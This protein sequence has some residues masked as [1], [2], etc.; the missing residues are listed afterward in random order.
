MD[1]ELRL[2]VRA[3]PLALAPLAMLAVRRLVAVASRPWCDATASAI[4]GLADAKVYQREDVDD[5]NK[6]VVEMNG[7]DER[8]CTKTYLVADK[9][10]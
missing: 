2:A 7:K 5:G 9:Y 4:R 10:R 1:A 3:L 6:I 8:S